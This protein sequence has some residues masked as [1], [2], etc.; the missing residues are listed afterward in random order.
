M[1]Q[2][3]EIGARLRE[4]LVGP[5]T[6]DAT[7]DEALELIKR[8]RG[9]EL[10]EKDVEHYRALGEQELDKLPANEVTE[11]LRHLMGFALKRLG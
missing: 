11:A 8:S 1:R 10:A 2:E 7:V 5:V 6:D 9:R 4:L 3:D